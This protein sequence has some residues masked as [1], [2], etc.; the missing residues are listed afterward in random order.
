MVDPGTAGAAVI[1]GDK[2]ARGVYGVFAG[3]SGPVK[4]L[5]LGDPAKEATCNDFYI[6]AAINGLQ[7]HKRVLRLRG[8]G[9]EGGTGGTGVLTFGD[10]RNALARDKEALSWEQAQAKSPIYGA[11][12]SSASSSEKAGY[13]RG[14]NVA[15]AKGRDDSENKAVSELQSKLIVDQDGYQLDPQWAVKDFSQQCRVSLQFVNSQTRAAQVTKATVDAGSGA[16]KGIWNWG[17][18]LF[19]GGGGGSDSAPAT[20][21]AAPTKA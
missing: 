16:V 11:N 20:G 3:D 17:K 5:G 7:T 13:L 10:V 9:G 2:L 8:A 14:T 18:G 4:K 12:D 6:Y 1:A 19:G 15:A 21:P